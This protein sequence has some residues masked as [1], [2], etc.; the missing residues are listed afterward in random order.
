MTSFLGKPPPLCPLTVNEPIKELI[1]KLGS[2]TK[3][4]EG[5][6]GE[7]YINKTIQNLA[8]HKV[9]KIIER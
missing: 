7:I 1:F 6:L 8:C 3:Q 9:N 5:E 2:L 4:A